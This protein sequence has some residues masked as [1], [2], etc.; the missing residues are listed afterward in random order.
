MPVHGVAPAISLAATATLTPLLTDASGS[1]TSLKPV[2]VTAHGWALPWTLVLVL[3]VLIA[4]I[5]GAYLYRRRNRAQRKVREDARVRDAVEQ[6]LAWPGA[7]DLLIAAPSSASAGFGRRR[8]S[9]A[10]SDRSRTRS[11]RSPAPPPARMPRSAA[12]RSTTCRARR[13]PPAPP[14]GRRHPRRRTGAGRR[15]DAGPARSASRSGR[16][17]TH[18]VT[19]AATVITLWMPLD[20]AA[21][22]SSTSP[23]PYPGRAEQANQP[24]VKPSSSTASADVTTAVPAV[25][26]RRVWRN[27]TVA[28]ATPTAYR[29][30]P[31]PPRERAGVGRGERVAEVHQVAGDHAGEVAVELGQTDHVEAAGG[32]GQC[33]QEP[34]RGPR[35]R[36]VHDAPSVGPAASA[37]ARSSRR[38]HRARARRG[39]RT[40][41]CPPRLRPARP[42]ERG[43]RPCG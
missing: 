28:A 9:P 1:T 4:G 36:S 15:R 13:R 27:G 23:K 11:R 32:R 3:V 30:P 29:Q 38:T 17:S 20:T 39:T 22:A 31:P 25:P 19:P 33:H 42:T 41:P 16:W 7:A 12:A 6:A 35:R 43:V 37:T 24:T 5:V 21:I 14:A 2:Q 40:F 10:G 18:P 26:T 34:G 8:F